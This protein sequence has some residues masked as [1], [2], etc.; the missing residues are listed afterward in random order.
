ML[1]ASDPGLPAG[2]IVRPWTARS[3]LVRCTGALF[4]RGRAPGARGS[5]AVPWDTSYDGRFARIAIGLPRGEARLAGARAGITGVDEPPAGRA[6]DRLADLLRP[7]GVGHGVRRLLRT[8]VGDRG[9]GRLVPARP[10]G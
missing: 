4:R 6:D 8:D 7:G 9:A 2:S 3:Y 10:G 1:P 5:P